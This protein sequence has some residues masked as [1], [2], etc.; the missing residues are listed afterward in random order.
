MKKTIP[1]LT[2]LSCRASRGKHS[3]LPQLTLLGL[4]LLTLLGVSAQAATIIKADDPDNLNLGTSWVG[5]T[6]PGVADIAQWDNTVSAA[7]TTNTLGADLTWYGL[8]I[9]NPAGAVTINAGNK[10]ALGNLNDSTTAYYVVDLTAATADLNLDCNVELSTG[11]N[12]TQQWYV[13]TSRTVTV[14]GQVSGDVPYGLHKQGSG[15]L[16]LANDNNNYT[17]VTDC[18]D[19]VVIATSLANGGVA[20]SLGA[21]GDGSAYAIIGIGA[22][23]GPFSTT[24]TF[25]YQGT[26]SAGHSSDR[27]FQMYGAA[28]GGAIDASGAGPLTLTGGITGG[29]QGSPATKTVTL[30]GEYTGG[31]NTESGKITQVNASYP[32]AVTKDGVCTWKLS[33]NN[34]FQGNMTIKAGTLV[35]GH[36]NALGASPSTTTLGDPAG[37]SA[38]LLID[39]PIN[40]AAR[41]I[42]VPATAAGTIT[43]GGRTANSSSF[44][45]TITLGKSVNVTNVS[46]GTVTFAGPISETAPSGLTTLGAGTVILSATNTYSGGTIVGAGTLDIAATGSILGNVQVT[47][48]A[49]LQLDNT[50]A[51]AAAARLTLDASPSASTVNLNFTGTQNISALYFGATQQAAGT[52][53][54]V[55]SGAA[56]P[57]AAFTGSGLLNIPVGVPCSQ[58][59]VALSVSNRLDGTITLTFHGTPGAYYYVVGSTEATNSISNWVPLS[60]STN[61][62]A[63][64]SGLWS[65]TVTNTVPQKFYRGAA[66]L[67]CL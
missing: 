64:P 33:G 37:S 8:A 4:G 19:G 47:N 52:W 17:G 14:N 1:F 18:R 66:V 12:N 55:G 20:C 16:I 23:I 10:L 25:R 44:T 62:A 3:T 50:N 45:Q 43:L 13:V 60:Y 56:N 29:T 15:T 51:L 27:K 65:C 48:G 32:T 31:D 28:T 24:G 35:L 2:S 61:Q 21:P 11:Q 57:N 34:N 30:K 46:S 41:P 9:V 6:A 67:P 39:G 38:F 22:N 26:N 49:V 7:N 54:A 53:G 5:G 58:T 36:A 59:N 42:T 40:V 63:S